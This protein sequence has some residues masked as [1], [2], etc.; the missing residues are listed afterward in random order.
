MLSCHKQYI[1]P[2]SSRNTTVSFI[3]TDRGG[4]GVSS[5]VVPTTTSFWIWPSNGKILRGLYQ[6]FWIL[7]LMEVFRHVYMTNCS[8]IYF[9]WLKGWGS[10]IFHWRFGFDGWW[11]ILPILFWSHELIG[12]WNF[13]NLDWFLWYVHFLTH[14]SHH[15]PF[16]SL[17]SGLPLSTIFTL[18]R[19]VIFYLY[20]EITFTSF[21]Y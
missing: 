15:L 12:V 8:Y 9:W 10:M 4:G 20:N 5:C 6:N 18:L 19:V 2:I 13:L 3:L 17:S 16:K 21:V 14:L 1:L 11:L 7:T